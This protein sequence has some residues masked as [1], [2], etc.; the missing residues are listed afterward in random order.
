MWDFNS[1]MKLRVLLFE[2]QCGVNRLGLIIEN[3][4]IF[5]EI[6]VAMLAVLS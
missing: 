3:E 4:M 6:S 5:Q 1:Y 2:R